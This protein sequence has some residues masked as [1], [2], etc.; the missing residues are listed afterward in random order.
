M[1]RIFIAIKIR[2]PL[3]G[4]NPRTLG[5]MASTITFTPLRTTD[6]FVNASTF[7]PNISH[8]TSVRSVVMVFS[9]F[10]SGFQWTLTRDVSTKVMLALAIGS[11]KYCDDCMNHDVSRSQV[12]TAASVKMIFCGAVPCSTVEIDRRFRGA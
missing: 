1:L 12:F 3:P 5:P 7:H 9:N 4:F 8:S 2:R 6:L 11:L 10:F